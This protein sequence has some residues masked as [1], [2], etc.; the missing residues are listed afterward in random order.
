MIVVDFGFRWL[1]EAIGA[2][3]TIDQA[4]FV[5]YTRAALRAGC[6]LSNVEDQTLVGLGEVDDWATEKV[7]GYS[8]CCAAAFAV[9]VSTL[10]P[11]WVDAVVGDSKIG[12]SQVFAPA[13]P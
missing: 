3:V 8:D 10:L 7:Q 12:D 6:P 11:A 9:A 13:P 5:T 1:W 4:G 2:V